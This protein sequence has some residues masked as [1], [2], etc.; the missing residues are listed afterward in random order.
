MLYVLFAASKE[1]SLQ[2]PGGGNGE[3]GKLVFSDT[4][5]FCRSL[6]LDE[7]ESPPLYLTG[8]FGPSFC[9]TPHRA[10][11]KPMG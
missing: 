3:E 8:G 6:Q 1:E 11:V 7:G 4:G 9:D 2:G 10:L 5:E